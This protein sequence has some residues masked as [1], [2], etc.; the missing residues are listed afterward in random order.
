M[1]KFTICVI[2]QKK[3]VEPEEPNQDGEE[4]TPPTEVKKRGR[5]RKHVIKDVNWSDSDNDHVE[6]TKKR[7]K[8]RTKKEKVC[9]VGSAYKNLYNTV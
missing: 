9:T 5:K 2:R 1:L 7:K 6:E 4:H 8:R 3:S